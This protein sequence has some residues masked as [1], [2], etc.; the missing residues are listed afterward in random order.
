[1]SKRIREIDLDLIESPIQEP[2]KDFGNDSDFVELHVYDPND[3]YLTSAII[4]DYKVDDQV[5]LKPG[6]DLRELGF[7]EGKYKV[8]YNFFRRKGPSSVMN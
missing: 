8:I 7:T 1:M 5:K 4:D 3:N 6:N 2:I